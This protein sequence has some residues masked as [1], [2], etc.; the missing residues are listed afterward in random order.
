M[1]VRVVRKRSVAFLAQ[2][3]FALKNEVFDKHIDITKGISKH[4]EEIAVEFQLVSNI[5]ILVQFL[6]TQAGLRNLR[7]KFRN[8]R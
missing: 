6:R 7:L 3:A 8:L 1:Y 2:L 4:F 5:H